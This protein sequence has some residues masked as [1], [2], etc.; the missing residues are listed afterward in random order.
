MDFKFFFSLLPLFPSIFFSLVFSQIF[1]EPKKTLKVKDRKRIEI[2][3][4]NKF[5]KENNRVWPPLT[6]L[7]RT[8]RP[9]A[10]HK[11]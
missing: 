10:C 9:Y 1:Q 6:N 5:K 3:R 11:I 2:I 4:I 8:P 7:E